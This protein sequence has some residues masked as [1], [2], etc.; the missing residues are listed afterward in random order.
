MS[1]VELYKLTTKDLFGGF[2]ASGTKSKNVQKLDLSI[3]VDRLGAAK[4]ARQKAETRNNENSSRSHAI[5]KIVNLEIL[6]SI[7][8]AL[9]IEKSLFFIFL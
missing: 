8:W 5:V 7:Y 1:F 2:G 4:K 3:A 9:I 6:A